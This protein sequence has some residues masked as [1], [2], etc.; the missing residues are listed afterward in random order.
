MSAPTNYSVSPQQ[1][2]ALDLLEQHASQIDTA[3][4]LALVFI[5]FVNL[6]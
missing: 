4:V 3:K 2:A 6:K 5:I 1:D